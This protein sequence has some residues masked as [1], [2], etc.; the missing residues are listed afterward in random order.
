MNEIVKDI[1]TQVSNLPKSTMVAL[2]PRFEGSNICSWIGFKHVMYLVEEGVL[3]YFRQANLVPCRLFEEHGLCLEIVDSGARILHALHMDDLAEIEVMPAA[4]PD[5][6]GLRLNVNVYLQRKGQRVKAVVAKVVVVFKLDDSPVTNSVAPKP[7]S[8]LAAY[9]VE[10]ISR[11][12]SRQ[13]LAKTDFA[14]ERGVTNPEDDVVRQLNASAANVFVWKWHIP[15]F[16]C[17]FTERMQHSGYLRLMEEVEDLFLADRGISIRQMLHEKK[18]IPV[19]P[20]ARVEI[21]EEAYM[22]EK[23]YTVYTLE[24]VY[25]EY[26]YTHRMDCYVVRDGRVIHT[27][28]GSITHGYAVINSR[29]DWS[30]VEIDADSLA[31]I[32]NVRS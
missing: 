25:R 9:T 27:A 1:E 3:D 8:Q 16:Y 2:R 5:P 32:N 17:H 6:T 22:E 28:T 24:N 12:S 26:T 13:D 15:Y 21:L 18:W 31:A 29:Q 20:Q 7:L 30:L 23:I 19:V 10:R 4:R 14:V 11:A